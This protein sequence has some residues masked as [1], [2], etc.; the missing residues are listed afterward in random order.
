MIREGEFERRIQQLGPL[1]PAASAEGVLRE[2]ARL[3]LFLERL[4][5]ENQRMNLVSAASSRP[6][7][8]VHRHLLDSLLG[9]EVLPARR[10]GGLSLLDIGSGGGFPAVPLLI[11]RDDIR[12][13]LVET[14]GKK[15]R[16][17]AE[18]CRAL[19]VPAEVVNA[20]FPDSFPMSPPARFDILTSRAV[21]RAGRLVRAARPLLSTGTG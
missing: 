7:E 5:A 9:I 3:A 13:T 19:A 16:F 17:L 2:A 8:L 18:T 20:R 12:G 10:A 4:L 1:L 15:C 6:E 14:T 21:S 11:V